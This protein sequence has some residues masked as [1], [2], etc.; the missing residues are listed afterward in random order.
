MSDP[1]PAAPM[2]ALAFATGI[3]RRVAPHATRLRV[4]SWRA[5]ESRMPRLDRVL[6]LAARPL[7]VHEHRHAGPTSVGLRLALTLRADGGRAPHRRDQSPAPAPAPRTAVSALQA[8][9]SPEP[10]RAR[11]DRPSR[12]AGIATASSPIGRVAAMAT[13]APVAPGVRRAPLVLRAATRAAA[14]RIVP[15]AVPFV[16]RSPAVAPAPS[17]A[18][19]TPTAAPVAVRWGEAPEAP[20]MPPLTSAD[21]PRVV[22]RVVGE[23]DRRLVAARE[24]RGWTA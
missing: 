7:V 17:R 22:D 5:G 18:E 2:R 6:R 15:S 10:R 16:H 12:D 19:V 23:I 21:I 11:S 4:R 1:F 24:R 8:W 13:V 9:R 14:S 20:A 3:R